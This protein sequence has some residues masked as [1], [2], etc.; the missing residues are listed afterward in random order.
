MPPQVTRTN[1]LLRL[2]NRRWAHCIQHLRCAY[3]VQ[4]RSSPVLCA[5]KQHG[6]R[7]PAACCWRPS[8]QPVIRGPLP[9][10]SDCARG[11][12][13]SAALMGAA[14][15]AVLPIYTASQAAAA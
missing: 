5:N 2:H 12:P 1:G 6:R 9:F 13:P 3:G 8:G 11:F 7:V 14:I 15:L 4:F 10:P